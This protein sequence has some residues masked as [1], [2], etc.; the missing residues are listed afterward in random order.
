ML[1]GMD[2]IMDT[3]VRDLNKVTD[4]RN[5][6]RLNNQQGINQGPIESDD[7]DAS[8]TIN[9]LTRKLIGSKARKAMAVEEEQKES[10]ERKAKAVAEEQKEELLK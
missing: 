10:K 4:F 9:S 2:P 5:I 1:E 3:I 8:P 7:D 6:Q